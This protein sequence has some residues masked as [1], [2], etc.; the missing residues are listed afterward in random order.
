MK[1]EEDSCYINYFV[2]K[3]E[4]YVALSHYK[5]VWDNGYTVD[6]YIIDD[7]CIYFEDASWN[8]VSITLKNK[9]QILSREF[10]NWVKEIETTKVLL[11]NMGRNARIS[12]A[13]DIKKGDFLFCI[14]PPY[15]E[16]EE[17]YYY[18]LEVVDVD[19]EK[20]IVRDLLIDKY[21][22]KF[23]HIKDTTI[24]EDNWL[25][26]PIKAKTAFIIKE[27]IFNKAINIFQQLTN[28]L[29]FEIKG[30]YEKSH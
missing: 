22:F 18:F 2:N 26:T 14:V 28:K 6:D 17:E 9:K 29:I 24:E 23:N 7:S 4:E 25:D 1:I 21:Y 20:I 19:N 16:E 15:D 13:E 3:G 8:G 10:N 27:T 5:E 12:Y 30:E 11:I